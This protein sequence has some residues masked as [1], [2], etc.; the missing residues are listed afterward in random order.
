MIQL[1]KDTGSSPTTLKDQWRRDYGGGACSKVVVEGD[2]LA[3]VGEAG[4][5]RR[6]DGKN[7]RLGE[8]SLLQRL[9]FSDERAELEQDR[10]KAHFSGRGLSRFLA[11]TSFD[12]VWRREIV[13]DFFVKG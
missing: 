13:S 6:A 4:S 7:K 10:L 12:V 1:S 9:T 5:R 8:I 2:L 3:N 11:I